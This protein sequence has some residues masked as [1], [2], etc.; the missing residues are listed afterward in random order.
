MLTPA[1]V[2]AWAVWVASIAAAPS[3]SPSSRSLRVLTYN[4]HHGEGTDGHFDLARLADIINSVSP[5]LVAL[6]E[7]D[8]GTTRAS[9]RFQLDELSQ[10]TGMHAAFGK[11]MDFQDGEYGVGVLSTR[12]FLR[13]E[14]H[15]LPTSADRELRTALTVEVGLGGFSG[16]GPRLRFTSTHLSQ[17]RDADDRL[18]Q[19]EQLNAMLG[20][21][22]VGLSI[23]AGD[24]NS[25]PETPVIQ[26]LATRWFDLFPQE[27]VVPPVVPVVSGEPP[28]FRGRVDYVLA[29]PF[30]R[31]QTTESRVID[32]R[33][34]SDHRPV[35][36]VVEWLG[37]SEPRRT[38]Q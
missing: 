17:G 8:Q 3:P 4:I 10:R 25:R 13:V 28:R 19:A 22:E 34:A 32:D 6:Q 2:L 7:V 38:L 20:G 14:N 30:N 37:E 1:W 35:L 18:A 26:T 12:P 29:R 23:L 15:P 9:G 27:A 21:D 11:A 16:G 24:L 31:W 5:D 36:V 33:L